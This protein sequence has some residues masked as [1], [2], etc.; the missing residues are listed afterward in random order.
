MHV[1]ESQNFSDLSITQRRFILS[2]LARNLSLRIVLCQK[3]LRG[4]LNRDCVI[5][6]IEDL[7]AKS[8]LL[9]CQVTDLP[10]IAG[11]NI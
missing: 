8:V 7:K 10:Q 3:L 6:G 1:P 4:L 9:D 2:H 5:R 11:V